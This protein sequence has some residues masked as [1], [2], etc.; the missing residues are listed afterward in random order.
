MT[1]G[2]ID[3]TYIGFHSDYEEEIFEL[4][5]QTRL[6]GGLPPFEKDPKL[7]DYA[8]Q[9]LEEG[10]EVFPPN[11]TT[12]LLFFHNNR[13]PVETADYLPWKTDIFSK[14]HEDGS[15]YYTT[16]GIACYHHFIFPEATSEV[17]GVT[18]TPKY[19]NWCFILGT[20]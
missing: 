9:S 7:Q 17:Y 10:R 6:E 19:L 13:G 8:R 1:V 14:V 2:P 3:Y 4:I 5:N 11:R 16:M 12:D 18:E 15:P 20:D